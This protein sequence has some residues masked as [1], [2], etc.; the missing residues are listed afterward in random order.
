MVDGL[1]RI[2]IAGESGKELTLGLMEPGDIF[3][4]IALLDGLPRTADAYAA[5]DS[6]LIVIDR[7][8]FMALL[9]REEQ[10]A[11]AVLATV[12]PALPP[13]TDPD[14]VLAGA[15][16]AADPAHEAAYRQRRDAFLASLAPI[17]SRIA[18]LRGKF[19]GAQVTA[20]EPVFGL[21]AAAFVFQR[22]Q[23]INPWRSGLGPVILLN[24]ALPFVFTNLNISIGGHIGGLI[25]GTI[26]ALAIERLGAVRRGDL[27]PVLA[28]VA[29]G[30]VSVVGAIAVS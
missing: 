3:G 15:L 19:S 23:G 29:V 13:D 22:A 21:M 4:E 16:G 5:E 2:C 10:R 27:Y 14:E 6:T 11:F 7:G 17:R 8:Q 26:A 9:E 24:L 25:G 12:V 1:I 30:A 28:C 18:A 20:T